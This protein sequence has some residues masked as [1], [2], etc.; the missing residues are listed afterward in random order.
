MWDTNYMVSGVNEYE[1]S[2]STYSPE[3]PTTTTNKVGHY[4]YFNAQGDASTDFLNCSNYL[5][6]T[7][8]VG[9][10][11]F[12]Q[13]SSTLSPAKL[14]EITTSGIKIDKSTS[15]TPVLVNLPIVI[16]GQPTQVQF[17]YPPGLDTFGIQFGVF[18][19][20]VQVLFNSGPFVVGTTYYAQASNAQ[21]LIIRATSNPSDTPLNCSSFTYGQVAFAYVSGSSPPVVITEN[22]S[23][24]DLTLINSTAN[25]ALKATDLTF[26]ET[27]NEWK[28]QL[29]NY[30]LSLQDNSQSLSTAI[31][32]SQIILDDSGSFTTTI[33]TNRVNITDGVNTSLLTTTGLSFNGIPISSSPA[34]NFPYTFITNVD[35]YLHS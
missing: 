16:S 11:Q 28:T 26:N 25:S 10:F 21:T 33:G 17:N 34:G 2:N 23:A 12:H 18:N 35:Y 9:G 19:N 32:P 27:A 3:Y 13:A 31:T 15:G 4:L 6:G 7:S 8:G 29:T 1:P 14:A 20:P 30:E 5:G 24:T 22:L